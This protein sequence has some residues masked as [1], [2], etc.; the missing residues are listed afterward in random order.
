MNFDPKHYFTC[1]SPQS[2]SRS[3]H[4]RTGEDSVDS[5]NSSLLL[6]ISRGCVHD[7]GY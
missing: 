5:L 7:L 6:F 2:L 3:M 1:E 4:L